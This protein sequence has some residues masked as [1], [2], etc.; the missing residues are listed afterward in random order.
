MIEDIK[1]ELENNIGK[2]VMI[3][4]NL[5]RNKYETYNAIIKETYNYIFLVKLDNEVYQEIKSFKYTDVI[6]NTIKIKL[7]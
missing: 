3:K 6:T 5:G 4:C 7:K 1:K 2:K